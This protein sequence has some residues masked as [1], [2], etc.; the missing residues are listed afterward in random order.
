MKKLLL[1]LLITS[2]IK[3]PIHFNDL[4]GSLTQ[5]NQLAFHYSP[6]WGAI[7]LKTGEI[8]DLYQN[9]VDNTDKS[10]KPCP[11]LILFRSLDNKISST[12]Q[13]T[14]PLSIATLQEILQFIESVKNKTF[15]TS[16]ETIKRQL[17]IQT[18]K[19]GK[20]PSILPLKEELPEWLKIWQERWISTNKVDA[21]GNKV[22]L[23]LKT[24]KKNLAIYSK[25]LGD[26]EPHKIYKYLGAF[27]CLNSTNSTDINNYLQ[28]VATYNKFHN[29]D[30]SMSHSKHSLETENYESCAISLL[31]KDCIDLNTESI[32]LS[33]KGDDH[34]TY[35]VEEVIKTIINTL[36][37][38]PDTQLLD[39]AMIS[40]T[41]HPQKALIEFIT[42]Y[43]NIKD[44]NHSSE[45]KNEWINLISNIDFGEKTQNIYAR[46]FIPTSL[47]T[48]SIPNAIYHEQH[49]LFENSIVVLNYLFNTHEPDISSF[50]NNLNTAKRTIECQE[51][52]E[53]T[54]A[55]HITYN[56][57]I[58][59][60][61]TWACSK[62]GHSNIHLKKQLTP[63]TLEELE[64]IYAISHA[65]KR[66]YKY[67]PN[68]LKLISN[69]EIISTI[70]NALNENKT[71]SQHL[72]KSLLTKKA[73]FKACATTLFPTVFKKNNIIFYNALIKYGVP[74]LYSDNEGNSLLHLAIKENFNTG[75]KQFLNEKTINKPNNEED[76]PLHIAVKNKNKYAIDLLV[77]CGADIN[78][79]NAEGQNPL[80]LATL[81]ENDI[82]S[83]A[84]LISPQNINQQNN[85]GDTPLHN[86]AYIKNNDAVIE[87]LCASNADASIE[88]NEDKTPIEIGHYN[89]YSAQIFTQPLKI[90]PTKHLHNVGSLSLNN[91]SQL[92]SHLLDETSPIDDWLT[93]SSL[94][95]RF[96][97]QTP[98]LSDQTSPRLSDQ[99]PR[100][101][102]QTLYQ[103][104]KTEECF[105]P[106]SS[107]FFNE[108]TF[109]AD[110]DDNDNDNYEE[111]SGP[112]SL[113]L[114]SITENEDEDN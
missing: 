108:T 78:L 62:A 65:F 43:A 104:D 23:N 35:C 26:Y 38:N 105:L 80:H 92:S 101:S 21:N 74:L 39:P 112:I 84:K 77:Q 64:S 76:A 72:I 48:S 100:L 56:D 18:S 81:E 7:A 10:Q 45:A 106:I 4:E 86:A 69:E 68:L 20:T 63:F 79:Q 70:K 57:T 102:D 98:R 24:F 12:N 29:I 75:I 55:L 99:T 61:G 71:P 3:A 13:P 66:R 88:N 103:N 41:I 96:S 19:K 47:H 53:N 109:P 9:S 22:Y 111:D 37:Y 85:L 107:S 11:L 52:A 28:T 73:F 27:I 50:F 44:F 113:Q 34:I 1:V 31:N 40:D 89:D 60:T 114:S 110:D 51:I 82:N 16:L 59:L 33:Y 87:L 8:H 94:S 30:E 93:H 32:C 46:K 83:I 5:L 2:T 14:N 54:L 36:F 95:I 91:I 17:E 90:K 15:Q 6:L 25:V 49:G 58:V 42:K 97:D 67:A